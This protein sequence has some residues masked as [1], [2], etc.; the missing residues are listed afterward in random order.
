[1]DFNRLLQRI[2]EIDQ[3]TNEGCG[4]MAP[5]PMTPPAA[6]V[7]PPSMSVNLNAQGMDNI[8]SLMKLMTKVNPDMINQPMPTTKP[9]GMIMPPIDM[10][11]NDDGDLD[12][13]KSEIA[14]A[15]GAIAGAAGRAALGGL[16][17]S[18]IST[19]AKALAL[20]AALSPTTDASHTSSDADLTNDFEEEY[21]NEPEE[22]VKDVDYILNKVSGGM[23]RPQG[24]YP[25]VAGGDN[26]M[27]KKTRMEGDELRAAIRTELQQRL[28]EAKGAK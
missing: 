6:T 25:K 12:G 19:G 9:V 26:P 16:A 4:E 13:T 10:D 1:M 22:E 3:S 8:E 5:S 11:G 18:A 15:I 23:N 2:A 14:P 20:P 24:T 21:A 28:A 27:Q 7:Q 17:R